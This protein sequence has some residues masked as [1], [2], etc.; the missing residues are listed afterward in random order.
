M[1]ER[2]CSIDGCDRSLL[3]RSWCKHHYRRWSKYG[4]PL[5]APPARPAVCSVGGCEAPPRT[6]G[7]CGKHY[8]RWRAHGDPLATS[9]HQPKPPCSIE[10]C[11]KTATG[12]TW[13]PMHY[14]R[15]RKHGSTDVVFQP[16]TRRYSLDEHYFDVIDTPEKAYWLGFIGADGCVQQLRTL[17]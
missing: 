5:G 7:W 2:M 9:W 4:D 1:T 8:S 15:W 16:D 6:R 14:E 11:E 10:G 13:C 3:A 12:R 17:T